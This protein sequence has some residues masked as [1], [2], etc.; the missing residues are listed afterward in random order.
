MTRTIITFIAS[1]T[2]L[3]TPAFARVQQFSGHIEIE[4]REGRYY[5]GRMMVNDTRYVVPKKEY[6]KALAHR[7]RGQD[8]DH[9]QRI[10]VAT[11]YLVTADGKRLKLR[12]ETAQQLKAGRFIA[13]HGRT[14]KLAGATPTLSRFLGRIDPATGDVLPEKVLSPKRTTISGIVSGKRAAGGWT[15]TRKNGKRVVVSGHSAGVLD[16]LSD[17]DHPVTMRGI[18][19]HNLDGSIKYVAFRS[20]KATAKGDTTAYTGPKHFGSINPFRKRGRIAKGRPMWVSTIAKDGF[21]SYVESS[22]RRLPRG[23]K[24]PPIKGWVPQAS[25]TWVDPSKGKMTRA[26]LEQGKAAGAAA[27]LLEKLGG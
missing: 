7:I 21:G 26:M 10:D 20:V 12:G 11:V 1:L 6:D 23:G 3:A 24:R 16:R 14:L 5:N 9:W 25:Y 19:F 17:L 4:W 18:L 15:L 2:F 22:R 27:A 8:A 13:S